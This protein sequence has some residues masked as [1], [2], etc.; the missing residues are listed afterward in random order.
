[1]VH[2]QAFYIITSLYKEGTP[3]TPPG[4]TLNSY[5]DLRFGNIH[6]YTALQNVYLRSGQDDYFLIAA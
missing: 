5:V 3:Y 2:R 6:Q 4:E 1:M